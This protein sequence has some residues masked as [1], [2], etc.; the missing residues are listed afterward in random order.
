[1]VNDSDVLLDLAIKSGVPCLVQHNHTTVDAPETVYHIRNVFKRLETIGITSKI[2]KPEMSMWQLI[3][4]KG[5]PPLRTV[6]YCCQILKERK[7][8]NQHILLGV[9]WDESRKR[10]ERGLHEKIGR[11]KAEKIIYVDENDDARRLQEICQMNNRIVTNPIVDWSNSDV[12]TYIRK[13]DIK[14]NPLYDRGYHRVGCLF[15]PMASTREKTRHLR[16]YPKYK[17]AYIVAFEKMIEHSIT[18]KKDFS[19]RRGNAEELFNWWIN[20]KYD[21]RQLTLDDMEDKM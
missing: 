12:W 20:E 9:R 6:R 1:M 16:E 21:P 5:M 4:K 3:A 2:N 14:Y 18:E 13:N 19:S 7:F 8:D 10:S 17:K 15:C 11:T